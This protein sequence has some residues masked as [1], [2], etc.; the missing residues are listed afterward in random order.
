MRIYLAAPLFSQVERAWNRLL[1]SAITERLPGSAVVLPQD[2]R[3]EGRYNDPKHYRQLFK[4]CL[5]EIGNADVMVAVL[6]GS[7]ADSGVAFE[8]GV[9]HTLGKTIV[10]L[11]TD[12]RPGADHGVNIMVSRA[13]R[14]IV[15]EFSFQED[16]ALVITS[17]VGR[18][19]RIALNKAAEK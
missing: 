2:F 1:A 8:A 14:Y 18:L 6:E 16:P 19:K 5:K 13:C 12:Y 15:R 9:A 4:R 11:R 7:D 3:L 10:G 17:L